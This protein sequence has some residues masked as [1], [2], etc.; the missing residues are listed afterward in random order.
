MLVPRGRHGN[1]RRLGWTLHLD[2]ADSAVAQVRRD[3]FANLVLE[4]DVPRVE[5]YVEFMVH[6]AV[7]LRP[8]DA[9]QRARLDSSYHKHSRLTAAD[10]AVMRLVEE[11]PCPS[12][13]D[14]CARVHAVLTYESGVTSVKTTAAEAL[15]VGRGVCQDFAHVMVTACRAS[16]LPARYV[17]GHLHGEGG[18]H[19]WVEVLE[20]D[21][22]RGT[23]AVVGWDPTHNRRVGNGYL[24]VAV[25]RDYADVAPVSGTFDSDSPTAGRLSVHKRV[26]VA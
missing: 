10:A 20:P 6:S 9:E 15:A 26:R 12:A 23:C 16:G 22:E 21:L 13:E 8:E 5:Q 7:E 2:G 24:T 4:V 17:S 18:S 1:Q 3:R 11:L 25:G 14:I 19:A